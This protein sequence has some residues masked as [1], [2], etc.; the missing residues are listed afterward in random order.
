MIYF[1][2]F[3]LFFNYDLKNNYTKYKMIN[4]KIL[5]IKNIFKMYLK[6]LKMV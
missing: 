5:D 6:I 2:Y 4:N 3:I 1:N